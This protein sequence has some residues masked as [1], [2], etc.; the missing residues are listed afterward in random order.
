M[1]ECHICGGKL[2][3]KI[4]NICVCEELPAIIVTNVPALVCERCENKLL[5]QEVINNFDRI[6]KGDA[7]EPV[8]VPSKL[9]DYQK[10]VEHKAVDVPSLHG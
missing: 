9:F 3:S 6:R 10:V 8:M 7:P 1:N 5:S 4:V 2:K